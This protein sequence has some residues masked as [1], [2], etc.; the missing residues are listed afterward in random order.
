MLLELASRLENGTY[1]VSSE[2]FKNDEE[3]SGRYTVHLLTGTVPLLAEF[4]RHNN[5]KLMSMFQYRGR[6]IVYSYFFPCSSLWARL[7][8]SACSRA[9]D[10]CPCAE[11]A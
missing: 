11:W 5:A 10:A 9:C 7:A 2:R 1:R 6:P 8:C 3:A 4:R